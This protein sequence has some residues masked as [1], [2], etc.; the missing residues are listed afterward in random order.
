MM[1]QQQEGEDEEGEGS[2]EELDQEDDCGMLAV[3]VDFSDED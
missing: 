2:E 3:I 1:V